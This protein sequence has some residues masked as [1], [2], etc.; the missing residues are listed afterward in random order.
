MGK[1]S[2]KFGKLFDNN[3]KNIKTMGRLPQ[4]KISDLS[5]I[6]SSHHYSEVIICHFSNV[7]S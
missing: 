4:V 7:K 1:S 5:M 6:L 2:T 3:D